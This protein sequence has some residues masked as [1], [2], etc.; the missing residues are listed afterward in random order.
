MA[1]PIYTA[2]YS[3]SD[4]TEPLCFIEKTYGAVQ[5]S[6]KDTSN[7]EPMTLHQLQGGKESRKKRDMHSI[8]RRDLRSQARYMGALS[9]SHFHRLP[10][11]VVGVDTGASLSHH[12]TVKEA[13]SSRF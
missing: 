2:L 8:Y 9:W 3:Q 6:T 1:K 5:Y 7:G 10:Y 4:T 13:S 12:P 11:S